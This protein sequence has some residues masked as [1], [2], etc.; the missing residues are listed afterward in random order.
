MATL[1][2]N[3]APLL[4]PD[5]IAVI[6]PLADAPYEQLGTWI[7]DGDPDLSVT[8]LTAIREMLGDDVTVRY[9]RAMETSRSRSTEGFEEAVEAARSADAIIAFLGEESILSGEAHSRANIDLPGDQAEL[10]RLVLKSV[11]SLA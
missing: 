11:A 5:S 3:L 7:F 2:V 9:V 4:R 8:P 10:V 1:P 6:G